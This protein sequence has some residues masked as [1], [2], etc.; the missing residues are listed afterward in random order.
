[1]D[2]GQSLASR[3]ASRTRIAERDMRRWAL[4]LAEAL[5]A[6]HSAGYSYGGPTPHSIQLEDVGPWPEEDDDDD[7]DDSD[8][9]EIS[10][11]MS[12]P[13]ITCFD[14]LLSDFTHAKRN[15]GDDNVSRKW[16]GPLGYEPPYDE[17]SS[18]ANDTK[19][20][21]WCFGCVLWEL[22]T[23]K[24]LSSLSSASSSR[25]LREISIEQA[26]A[27]VP[28]R[29]DEETRHVL[30]LA[31][32]KDPAERATAEDLLCVLR[33]QKPQSI[34]DL[35]VDE[36]GIEAR[37]GTLEMNDAEEQHT[38]DNLVLADLEPEAIAG[39]KRAIVRV[40]RYRRKK[41]WNNLPSVRRERLKRRREARLAAEERRRRLV[42]SRHCAFVHFWNKSDV[43]S[44]ARLAVKRAID[45]RAFSLLHPRGWHRERRRWERRLRRGEVAKSP[46]K[47]EKETAMIGKQT[48]VV[49]PDR[50]VALTSKLDRARKTNVDARRTARLAIARANQIKSLQHDAE[51]AAAAIELVE[52]DFACK[53]YCDSIA[54]CMDVSGTHLVAAFRRADEATEE[55]L[56]KLRVENSRWT[57]GHERD[58]QEAERST[59]VITF[60]TSLLP[61]REAVICAERYRKKNDIHIPPECKGEIERQTF[62]LALV[63]FNAYEATYERAVDAREDASAR[64]QARVRGSRVRR[65]VEKIW[66]LADEMYRDEQEA[67]AAA[68]DALRRHAI[69]NPPPKP[70]APPAVRLE[71][72]KARQAT[73]KL[74]SALINVIERMKEKLSLHGWLSTQNDSA[75]QIVLELGEAED[76]DDFERCG[77]HLAATVDGLDP[78][79]LYRVSTRLTRQ[80]RTRL[81]KLAEGGHIFES[82]S[83]PFTFETRPDVPDCPGALVATIARLQGVV[84]IKKL[85]DI[86]FSTECARLLDTSSNSSIITIVHVSWKPPNDNGKNV[87][88]YICERSREGGTW[89]RLKTVI[90]AINELVDVPPLHKSSVWFYRVAADNG[91]GRGSFSQA[92]RIVTSEETTTQAPIMDLNSLKRESHRKRP[93]PAPSPAPACKVEDRQSA[94]LLERDQGFPATFAKG[95]YFKTL[96][97]KAPLPGST[98]K[99][100]FR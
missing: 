76:D 10:S 26:I 25:P 80:T 79:T 99:T 58:P 22:A 38:I 85:V 100:T 78:A 93:T 95:I 33:P 97:V 56:E 68:S 40:Q 14:L 24:P 30:R 37:E 35:A 32:R 87:T 90:G 77:C 88:R 50:V 21:V 28:S 82:L 53:R 16:T 49:A 43:A 47:T 72:S 92:T 29:F 23:R 39:W 61:L 3:L 1:M 51:A 73:L 66:K 94:V 75:P 67:N 15:V 13:P 57:A 27:E 60:L 9:D 42:F 4:C 55:S 46:E 71:S 31:L 96:D 45:A 69:A 18:C 70:P 12:L 98:L 65:K 48:V 2:W 19:V 64:I 74:S 17:I 52:L 84:E 11:T 86:A 54:A 8:Y 41:W 59:L 44:W 89:M 83:R 20:D 63:L 62:L 91:V 5:V 81:S 36:D 6:V 7:K 34:F